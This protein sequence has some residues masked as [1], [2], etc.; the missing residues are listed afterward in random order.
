MQRW[1]LSDYKRKI[2]FK[3]LLILIITF[4]AVSSVN[5]FVFKKYLQEKEIDTLTKSVNN[6]I[7]TL[8]KTYR[9][10]IWNI[11]YDNIDALNNA[12]LNNEE[13]V[14]INIFN[15][16]FEFIAG[17]EKTLI[18]NSAIIEDRTVPYNNYDNEKSVI[19][20]NFQVYYNNQKIANVELFYTNI[21]ALKQVNRSSF[22]I[23]V[24]YL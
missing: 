23:S 7:N 9:L 6:T 8:S 18:N 5:I 20:K 2:I 14:A 22:A 4:T 15:E 3:L 19:K 12:I 13:Y 1:Q 24:T 21:Y 11:D 10:P 16:D 17:C